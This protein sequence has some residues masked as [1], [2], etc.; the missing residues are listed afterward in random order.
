ML[1]AFNFSIPGKMS[2]VRDNAF[3]PSELILIKCS[4][5]FVYVSTS[6]ESIKSV[7]ICLK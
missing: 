3:F 2:L 6:F 7:I 1:S 5:S 4:E